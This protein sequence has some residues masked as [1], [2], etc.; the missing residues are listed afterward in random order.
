[1]RRAGADHGSETAI[2]RG[3]KV[4]GGTQRGMRRMNLES[5]RPASACLPVGGMEVS[6]DHARHDS[7]AIER[8]HAVIRTCLNSAFG[9]TLYPVAGD[10]DAGFARGP[11]AVE[12]ISPIQYQPAH[13]FTLARCSASW[14]CRLTVSTTIDIR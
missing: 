10:D 11:I 7:A 3:A 5:Q 14:A 4:G 13:A 1:M 12:Q 9:H 2:E 6:L 8:H